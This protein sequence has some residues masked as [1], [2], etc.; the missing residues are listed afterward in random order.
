MQALPWRSPRRSRPRLRVFATFQGPLA[1]RP[2]QRPRASPARPHRCA[3]TATQHRCSVRSP[4]DLACSPLRRSTHRSH[5]GSESER[6]RVARP[7]PCNTLRSGE[8]CSNPRAP[9]TGEQ[10]ASARAQSAR[11]RRC[12][13]GRA[14]PGPSLRAARGSA[15]GAARKWCVVLT[16]P[17]HSLASG[18]CGS[19][20]GLV[21]AGALHDGFALAT[22]VKRRFVAP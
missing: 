7:P 4:R 17:D 18:A 20:R 16:R 5:R 9:P 19:F 13:G 3:L 2:L 12:D 1:C 22:R 6:S 15:V 10:G 21:D 11:G 8:P 14:C